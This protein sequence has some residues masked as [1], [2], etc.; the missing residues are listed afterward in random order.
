LLYLIILIRKIYKIVKYKPEQKGVDNLLSRET[1]IQILILLSKDFE[2]I[3][4]NINLHLL[5]FPRKLNTGNLPAAGHLIKYC[6][7]SFQ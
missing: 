7:P 6:I 1:N 3:L 5:S 2:T 4:L